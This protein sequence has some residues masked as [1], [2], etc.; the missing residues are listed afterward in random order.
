MTGNRSVYMQVAV[1]RIG[2]LPIQLCYK[3]REKVGSPVGDRI[4]NLMWTVR[5]QVQDEL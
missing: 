5:D 1:P 2:P 4:V 3:I